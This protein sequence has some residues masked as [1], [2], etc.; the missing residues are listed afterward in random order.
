MPP[1]DGWSLVGSHKDLIAKH[2]GNQNQPT[3]D[4]PYA[5]RDPYGAGGP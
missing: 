4:A 1:F 3:A 5:G 2:S